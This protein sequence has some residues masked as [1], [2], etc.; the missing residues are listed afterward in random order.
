MKSVRDIDVEGKRVFVR[1]DYNLP[2]DEQ[3]NITDDNR[4]RATLDLIE[5]LMAHN[6]KI[7]LA[8]H[9]G[10]PDGVRDKKFSL[11]PAALR[12]AEILDRKVLFVDD[13]IGEAVEQKVNEL[14]DGQI[15]LLENLRF[16]TEEKKN[17]LAFAKKLAD[18][19]DVYINN[20]FAVSHRTQASITGTPKFV[21]Q[22]CAGFLLEKEV[23]SYTDSV[24]HP[25]KPL[26]A[27]IGGAKVS[28]KLAA[29]ENMLNLV[30]KLL[31]GGAMANTFLRAKGVDT[32]GS[33]IEVDLL[34][35]A[36]VILEKADQ[37][38]IKLLLPSDLVAADTFDKDAA[39]KIVSIDKIPDNWMALDIG[40]KNSRSLCKGDSGCRY[41]CL[42]WPHGSV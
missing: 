32:R 37:R 35:I 28:S 2:M 5:Y 9:L 22:A 11:L 33:M 18:L 42:E 21:A 17:D 30:D 25:K 31:I 12:L 7:I 19:C 24:E 14:K 23:K 40:P 39:T 4:I 26:V 20:A 1:V 34:K 6:A 38:G 16:H 15:L 41:H 29:L 27:V 36:G 8:S 13:C 3:L 10:R